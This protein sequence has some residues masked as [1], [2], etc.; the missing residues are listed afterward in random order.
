MNG[1]RKLELL[2]HEWVFGAF[3][4]I[5]WGRLLIGVGPFDLTTLLFFILLLIN[6]LIILWSTLQ[7][8]AVTWRFR[9]WFYPIV[10]NVVFMNM[11]SA[12]QKIGGNHF[13][14]VLAGYDKI[15]F[16]EILSIRAQALVTPILTEILSFCYLLFFPYLM[17]SWF[18]YSRRG[19]PVFRKLVI[20]MFT[21]YGFGFLGYSLVPAAGPHLAFPGLFSVPFVGWAITRFNAIVVENGS[22]GV[23]VFPSLHC[24]VSCFLLFF[25]RQHTPWRYRLYFVPCIG[26]WLATIYL[27]Y[28][29]FTDLIVGFALA[30]FALSLV[31]RWE[32]TTTIQ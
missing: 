24:A 4:M 5:L 6:G 31:K 8:T 26:I 15:F 20:G 21:I 25:D 18:Y 9:L 27:R 19:L 29:Y 2:P 7:E 13:D 1:L 17:I 22:N 12:L 10:I 28:H 16:G 14:S 3:L 30:W 11:K 23:D 32:K